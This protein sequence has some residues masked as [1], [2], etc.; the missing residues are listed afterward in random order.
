MEFIIVGAIVV[1][2]I[3][4]YFYSRI[5]RSLPY[6]TIEAETALPDKHQGVLPSD[7][8]NET[9]EVITKKTKSPRKPKMRIVE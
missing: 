3:F 4:A 7:Q 8:C 5:P 2:I 1:G 9:E 6:E